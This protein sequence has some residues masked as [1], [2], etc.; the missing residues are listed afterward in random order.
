M[1][2][3]LHASLLAA[4]LSLAAC[5]GPAFFQAPISEPGQVRHDERLIGSWYSFGGDG[6]DD[7]VMLVRIS[8]PEGEDQDRLDAVLTLTTVEPA[9][10]WYI[11]EAFASE[12]D[13]TVYYNTRLTGAAT[14]GVSDDS[15]QLET[16]AV[17]AFEGFMI[18]QAEVDAD[19]QLSLRIISEKQPKALQLKSHETT[20]GEDCDERLYE[21]SSGELVELIRTTPRDELFDIYLG[22]FARIWT[23]RPVFGREPPPAQ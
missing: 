21:L 11:V 13:G 20:C 3:R 17:G 18:I 22:P 4:A 16:K 1:P 10:G 7:G 23:G 8:A 19:E 12:I 2:R 9:T 5:D 14:I 15:G 6:D